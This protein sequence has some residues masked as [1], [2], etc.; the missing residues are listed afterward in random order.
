MVA[1]NNFFNFH[2]LPFRQ[3]V[4]LPILL[5]KP[6]FIK[7]KGKVI[8]QADRVSFGMI[9][10]GTLVN[11]CNPNNGITFDIDG[12]LIFKG[13][14][15]FANDSYIMIRDNGTITI[16]T[17]FDGNCKLKCAKSIEIGDDTVIAYDSMVMDSDWHALTDMVTGKLVHKTAPVKIGNYNLSVISVLLPKVQ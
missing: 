8:I 13:S 17:R 7:L 10:M 4:K 6:H 11:T 12:T 1:K 5:Q 15:I 3:A 16:G 9:Q 2:Y 14:A